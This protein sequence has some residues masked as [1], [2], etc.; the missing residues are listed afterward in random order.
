M[1]ADVA[2]SSGNKKVWNEAWS[3]Q[4]IY[5]D[6]LPEAFATRRERIQQCLQNYYRHPVNAD[7]L[8]PWSIMHGILSYGRQSMV[9]TQGHH[10]NAIDYLA[11]NGRGHDRQLLRLQNGKL[12]VNV[13]N[14][15]QGHEGQLLAI[16]AQVNAPIDHPIQWGDN[17]LTIADLVE[18]E[19][20]TCIPRTELTFKLIG[21]SYYLNSDETWQDQRG[22]NWDI[23]RLIE[24]E[25]RQPING[26]ACGGTHRLMGLSFSVAVRHSRGEPIDGAWKRAAQFVNEYHKTALRMINSDGTFSAEFFEGRSTSSDPIKLIYST[27]HALEWLA[28]SLDDETLLS[29]SVSAMVDALLRLMESDFHPQRPL[30]GTDVGPKG[31]ALRAL[32]LYALRMYGEAP[33]FTQFTVNQRLPSSELGKV[34]SSQPKVQLVNPDQN[35]SIS[36]STPNRSAIPVRGGRIMRRR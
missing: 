15:F 9:T 34:L 31:H 8:R 3:Q 5:R 29:A 24:E 23:A 13:G 16:L 35:S 14:G 27:G 18:Y 20:S 12:S 10:I 26:A 25:L 6:E 7:R 28:I 17:H 11:A 19:K 1:T 33:E 21:L 30:V 32:R 22:G 36:D 2:D 4:P